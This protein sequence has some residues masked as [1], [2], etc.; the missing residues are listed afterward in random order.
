[1]K[2]VVAYSHDQSYRVRCIDYTYVVIRSE[3][4]IVSRDCNFGS[5]DKKRDINECQERFQND[6]F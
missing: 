2:C 3:V 5:Q 1:M 6:I 4:S